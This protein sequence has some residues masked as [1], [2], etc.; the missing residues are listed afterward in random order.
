MT[1]SYFSSKNGIIQDQQRIAFWNLQPWQATC[2]SPHRKER[3]TLFQ[4]PFTL[5]KSNIKKKKRVQWG[6][7]EFKMC[8]GFSLT[9][10]TASHGCAVPR[11]EVFLL[12]LGFCCC[13]R[14]WQRPLLASQLYFNWGFCLLVFTM[15]IHSIQPQQM[16]S[17]STTVFGQSLLLYQ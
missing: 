11:Q 14:A 12:P 17:Q 16:H 2:K 10:V 1:T 9:V 15:P 4:L 3:R 6:N 13:F 7:W 8:S 5:F